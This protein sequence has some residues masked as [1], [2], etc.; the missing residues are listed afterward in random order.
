MSSTTS[1]TTISSTPGSP[2]ARVGS[3]R[4]FVVEYPTAPSALPHPVPARAAVR[5]VEYAF[6]LEMM[7]IN[8][9]LVT[10]VTA[11][12]AAREGYGSVRGG[13]AGTVSVVAPLVALMITRYDL[14]RPCWPSWGCS[15]GWVAASFPPGRC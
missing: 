15:S 11:R 2:S 5:G 4:D 9:V 13:W 1:R 8:A 10:L 6:A 3:Y 14:A 12:V 7:V